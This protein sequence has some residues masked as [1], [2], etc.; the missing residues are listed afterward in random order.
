MVRQGELGDSEYR[1]R[2]EMERVEIAGRTVTGKSGKNGG[3][4]RD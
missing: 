3:L 2:G 4:T 1:G